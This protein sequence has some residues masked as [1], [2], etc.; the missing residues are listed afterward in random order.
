MTTKKIR[1]QTIQ[2]KSIKI[3]SMQS[4]EMILTKLIKKKF[5]INKMHQTIRFASNYQIRNRLNAIEKNRKKFFVEINFIIN[6]NFC[7]FINSTNE[8]IDDHFNRS[9]DNLNCFLI[10]NSFHLF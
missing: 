3:T 9:I 8:S 6:L 4:N 7:F 5:Q 10:E 1:F 2:I